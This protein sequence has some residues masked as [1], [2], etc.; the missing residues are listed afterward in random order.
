M[1]PPCFLLL[2]LFSSLLTLSAAALPPAPLTPLSRPLTITTPNGTSLSILQSIRIPNFGIANVWPKGGRPPTWLRPVDPAG[3]NILLDLTIA[4]Y[5]TRPS[6]GIAGYGTIGPESSTL[7]K[8]IEERV[9][10]KQW[11]NPSMN[12]S[13]IPVAPVRN[14]DVAYAAEM[15]KNRYS[16]PGEFPFGK[17]GGWKMLYL[18][19]PDPEPPHRRYLSNVTGV[20][21]V[22]RDLY[23]PEEPPVQ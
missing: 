6:D 7:L 3:T 19:D 4:T 2:L 1:F 17:E 16:R 22:Q 10:V 8:G 20:L 23:F 11:V 12:R 15:I 18:T 21:L 5:A 14:R 13:R 9:V